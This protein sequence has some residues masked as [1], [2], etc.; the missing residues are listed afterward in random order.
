MLVSPGGAET[1]PPFSQSSETTLAAWGSKAI[2]L[3]KP[4]NH[5]ASA[6]T[7]LIELYHD[8]LPKMLGHT[9]W[10]AGTHRA[11][12][13]GSEYLNFEFGFKPLANDIANFAY[14]VVAMDRLI[15][16]Y[17][18]DAGRVVRRK[19]SFPP[20]DSIQVFKVSGSAGISTSPSSTGLYDPLATGLGAVYC[21]K[22]TSVKRWFSGAFTYYIPKGKKSEH[23]GLARKLLGIELTPE[24]IWNVAPWSWAV[25]WFTNVGDVISNYQSWIQDGLVLQYGY[26]ME[27]SLSSNT[28]YWSGKT[29]YYTSDAIPEPITFI[30]ES[31]VRRKATPFG[32]GVL[33]S[34][35]TNRQKAISAAL[36][37]THL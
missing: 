35:L 3:C 33:L 14:G 7:A 16:Q 27:H 15:A 17:E 10:E 25:D 6:A 22:K 30:T 21:V 9:L 28:Y 23:P 26:I 12:K 13:A 2:A 19:W 18:R 8:G 36:G 20:E 1:F 31:K 5:V 32:F 4:T 34:G 11:R 29:G 24:V 37:L